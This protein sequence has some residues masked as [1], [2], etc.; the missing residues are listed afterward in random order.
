MGRHFPNNHKLLP[1][2]QEQLALGQGTIH[3]SFIV[4][5]AATQ[6]ILKHTNFVEPLGCTF[7]FESTR[8]PCDLLGENSL[9]S[10]LT[11][12]INACE[13]KHS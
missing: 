2:H 7:K 12:Y 6:T 8:A 9:E 5:H 11:P 13:V 10:P 1:N 3:R 4:R